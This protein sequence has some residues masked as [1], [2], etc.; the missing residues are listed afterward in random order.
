MLAIQVAD[1]G[2]PATEARLASKAPKKAATN[3]CML[4]VQVTANGLSATEG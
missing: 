4:A 2:L 3:L 1:N